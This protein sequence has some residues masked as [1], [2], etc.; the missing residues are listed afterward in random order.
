MGLSDSALL[1]R[2]FSMLTSGMVA[3]RLGECFGIKK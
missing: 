1:S 2:V 3:A